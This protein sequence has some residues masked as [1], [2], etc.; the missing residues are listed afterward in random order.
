[1]KITFY[2]GAEEVGRSCILVSSGNTNILL[3]AGVKLGTVVEH[4]QIPKQ[5]LDKIDAIFVSH[6]HMDH[7]GY[8]PHLFSAGYRGKIYATKPTIELTNVLISDY[9]RISEPKS[10]S[11]RRRS[12]GCRRATR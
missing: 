12:R 2:G 9:M 10:M 8:L 5:V 7:V 4:P 11:Q 3:D 6:A 1:M